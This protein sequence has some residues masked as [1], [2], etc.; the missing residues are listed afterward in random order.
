MSPSL[1]FDG[2]RGGEGRSPPCT[3]A[4]AGNL[5]ARYLVD[6]GNIEEALKNS[7]VVWEKTFTCDVASHALPEPFTAIAS[8]EPSGKFNLWMQTQ[9]PFQTRQGLSN[10][11]KV[12]RAISVFT[13]CP[14]A[15]P[16]RTIRYSSGCLYRMPPFPESRKTCSGEN[17]P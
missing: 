12:A 13:H 17:D 6:E 3:R 7:D 8:Y 2:R 14:W 16:R 15:E 5:A 11:L 4:Q 10:T 9:C 1:R